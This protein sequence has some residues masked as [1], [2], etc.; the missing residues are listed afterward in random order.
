LA[1]GKGWIDIKREWS[2]FGARARDVRLRPKADRLKRQ[3]GCPVAEYRYTLNDRTKQLHALEQSLVDLI[4]V[5]EATPATINLTP[6]YRYAL[7]KVTALIDGVFDQE[8]LSNLARA[9]PDAF[10]RHKD[11]MSPL[12][13]SEDGHWQEP[14]WFK[15][16]DSKLLSDVPPN[17]SGAPVSSS[18]PH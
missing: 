12:E 3:K 8:D 1:W 13:P 2:Q 17:L 10:H 5:A 15:R 6:Q 18:I 11:W 16:L 4:P 7:E 9:I 14:E